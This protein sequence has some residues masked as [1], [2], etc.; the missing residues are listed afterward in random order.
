MAKLSRIAPEIPVS[1][2]RAA[3][4]YY[5]Q[6]LGFKAVTEMPGAVILMVAE[7]LFVVSVTEVAVTVT[8][9]GLGIVLGAV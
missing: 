9:A 4:E 1:N 7:A 2:L 5:E 8:V 6:K 3:I